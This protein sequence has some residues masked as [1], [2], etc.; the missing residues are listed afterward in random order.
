MSSLAQLANALRLMADTLDVLAFDDTTADECAAFQ[1]CANITRELAL[2]LANLNVLREESAKET[3]RKPI[4][5]NVLAGLAGRK[6]KFP[7]SS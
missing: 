3:M 4:A 1:R 7:V 2:D 6:L 5:L